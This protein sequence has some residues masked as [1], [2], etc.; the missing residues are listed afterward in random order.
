MQKWSC[1]KRSL[2]SSSIS[3]AIPLF[4]GADAIPFCRNLI[5]KCDFGFGAVDSLS[6]KEMYSK[7]ARFGCFFV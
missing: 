6:F 7:Q 1:E 5:K 3:P 2:K 4:E